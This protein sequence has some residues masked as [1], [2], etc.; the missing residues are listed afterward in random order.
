VWFDPASGQVI[1]LQLE[2]LNLPPDF[3]IS[4]STWSI[5]YGLESIV[6]SKH[7]LPVRAELQL[8]T[9]DCQALPPS[10]RN[11]HTRNLIEF[12]N[13]HKF[14]TEVKVLLE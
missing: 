13:Y 3:P 11:L 12:R 7:W 10:G 14:G 8:M 6:G 9:S 4:R 5:D 1:R 2:A